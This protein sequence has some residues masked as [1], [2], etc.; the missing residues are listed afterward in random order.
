LEGVKRGLE[1]PARDR[2]RRNRWRASTCGATKVRDQRRVAT[3]ARLS[4][5]PL[6]RADM[7]CPARATR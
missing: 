5:K 1:Q 6:A 2:P 3:T 7:I 4:S